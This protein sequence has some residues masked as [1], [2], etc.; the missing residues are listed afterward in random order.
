[1]T[2]YRIIR[3][4][5]ALLLIFNERGLKSQH[6]S[7]GEEFARKPVHEQGFHSVVAACE[8]DKPV[9]RAVFYYY[10]CVNFRRKTPVLAAVIF[11]YVR[12]RF[13]YRVER[14]GKGKRFIGKRGLE[15]ESLPF[16][17]FAQYRGKFFKV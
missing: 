1:M 4:G 15:N 5:D 2:R 10:P 16:G 9:G 7:R 13:F 12:L 6:L 11:R 14:G 3:G 17:A 8:P